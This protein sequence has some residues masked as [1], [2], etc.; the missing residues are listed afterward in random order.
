MQPAQNDLNSPQVNS[1]PTLPE[2][3]S[4]FNRQALLLLII[5]AFFFFVGLGRFPLLEPDEGRNAEV[6][7]EMIVL[8]DFITPHFNHLVYLDKPALFFWMVAGS[9]KVFGLSE[10]A[11]RFPSALMALGTVLLVWLMGRSMFRGRTGFLAACVAASSPLVI[12]FSRTVIFDMTL[13]FLVTLSMF[14]FWLADDDAGRRHGYDFLAF[15]VMG[16]AAITKGPVGLLLPLLS[17]LVYALLRGEWSALRRIRWGICGLI[18]LAVSMP[19][20]LAV[21]ARHPDFPRYAFW[22][23]SLVRFAT[24]ALHRSGGAFYYVPVYLAG[25]LPWS[26]FLLFA[27][28]NHLRRWRNLRQEA[29]KATLF[30]IAWF[31]LIFVFFS[32]SHS[33]LP[34]YLLPAVA[35]ISLLMGGVWDEVRNQ[36]GGRAPDW[37]RGGFATLI[38]LGVLVDAS[39]QLLRFH[40][41]A[42][43]LSHKMPPAV[44]G[45]LKPSV[46]LSG[47]ILFALGFLGRNL[48]G[49]LRGERW[50]WITFILLVAT[51][52]LLLIRWIKPLHLYFEASSS[53]ALAQQILSSP[54]R[55]FPVYGYFYFRTGLPFYLRRPEG[56]ITRDGDEMTSNYVMSR[57]QWMRG[58]KMKFPVSPSPA[59]KNSAWP[60]GE[61]STA[62]TRE[63]I[64]MTPPQLHQLAASPPGPFLLLVRNNEV[65]QLNRIANDL[66]PLWTGWDFSVWAKRP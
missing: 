10:W 5:S 52:P 3:R 65:G 50:A 31:A 35:P 25:F 49:R 27:G 39:P 14:F 11:A 26:F 45:L 47:M 28:L 2:G 24:P 62:A 21:W 8:H 30:L 41:L 22:E 6:A 13:A 20:F 36:S 1:N 61:G 57:L 17:I 43:R 51:T 46:I 40:G 23:E 60:G 18:F 9:F 44:Y 37:L 34:G 56:L 38:L 59:R 48:S 64:L 53:R 29:Q 55:D 54:E 33:K 42:A 12:A 16:L 19:W 7:R 15:G 4:A 32:I 66:D 58:Q 63:P